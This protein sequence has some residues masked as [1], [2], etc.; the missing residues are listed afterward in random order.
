MPLTF[1]LLYDDYV[2]SPV[3]LTKVVGLS[4]RLFVCATAGPDIPRQL[5]L[6]GLVDSVL[7]TGPPWDTADPEYATLGPDGSVYFALDNNSVRRVTPAGSDSL[8]ASWGFATPSGYGI[9][10]D[11]T[12][13]AWLTSRSDARLIEVSA[14]GTLIGTHVITSQ[15]GGIDHDS[16]ILYFTGYDGT[17]YTWT[18]ATS[19]QATL[20][21]SGGL[22]AWE[23]LAIANGRLYALD[24]VTGEVDS[25]N[26]AGGDHVLEHD[27]SVLGS[28]DPLGISYSAF[29]SR[30]YAVDTL[31]RIYYAS[32]GV[33]GWR[34]GRV[35]WPSP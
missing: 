33:A 13:K 6:P 28:G 11:G 4:D 35:H 20:V 19:T 29:D 15:S 27:G 2:A 34:T 9:T 32:L 21:N 24:R 31:G 3:G 17:I 5:T 23:D 25:Y 26:L 7:V 18:I 30:L 8:W 1:N 16:G 22:K 12:G 14:A 10:F